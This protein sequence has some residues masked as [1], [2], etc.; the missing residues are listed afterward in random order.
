M[1]PNVFTALV[2]SCRVVPWSLWCIHSHCD[3]IYKFLG[4]NS[5]LLMSCRNV[6]GQFVLAYLTVLRSRGQL[7]GLS[8]TVPISTSV[9]F[10]FPCRFSFIKHLPPLTEELTSRPP[11]RACG[12]VWGNLLPLSCRGSWHP[13]ASKCTHFMNSDSSQMHPQLNFHNHN[14]KGVKMC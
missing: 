11:G 3:A 2:W 12:L 4:K 9:C 5:T 8:T 13:I 6:T 1:S 10:S 7:A 14:A